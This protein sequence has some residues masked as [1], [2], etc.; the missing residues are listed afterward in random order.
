V[1]KNLSAYS[2]V[3]G[4]QKICSLNEPE[5]FNGELVCA[6]IETTDDESIMARNTELV[7]GMVAAKKENNL[8]V[9]YLSIANIVELKS[10][11]RELI[12]VWFSTFIIWDRHIISL[13]TRLP[14]H[15]SLFFVVQLKYLCRRMHTV[16]L[17]LKTKC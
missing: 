1:L 9:L 4:V 6:V 17:F 7:V 16:V 3:N 8:E 2:L 12:V 15:Y 5:G 10:R 11:V 13:Q 14:S